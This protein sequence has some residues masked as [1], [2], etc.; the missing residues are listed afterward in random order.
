MSIPICIRMGRYGDRLN[1]K[2]RFFRIQSLAMARFQ[3]AIA[4][5]AEK[6]SIPRC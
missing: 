2:D 1:N 6:M 5:S 3:W 4:V